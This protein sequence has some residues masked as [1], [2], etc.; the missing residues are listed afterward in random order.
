MR[1]EVKTTAIEAEKVLLSGQNLYAVAVEGKAHLVPSEVFDLFYA[2]KAGVE[3][4][5][6]LSVKQTA[7]LKPAAPRSAKPVSR[8]KAVGNERREAVLRALSEGP[9][10]TSEL[11]DHAYADQPDKTKRRDACWQI[12]KDMLKARQIQRV[13]HNGL[14]KWALPEAR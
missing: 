10:T 6:P 3:A 7:P 11:A 12:S 4:L 13:E 9:L 8:K 5:K 2:L 1:Y 14:D